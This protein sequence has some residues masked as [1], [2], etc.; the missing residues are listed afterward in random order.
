MK[1]ILRK[2]DCLEVLR[3]YPEESLE[4]VLCDP[5]YGVGFM[6]DWHDMASVRFANRGTLTN[7]VNE[8]SKVKF[9]LKAPSFRLSSKDL[10]ELTDWHT[11]WLSEAKRLLVTGGTVKIFCSNR[12]VHKQRGLCTR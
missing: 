1:L 8:D 2:G 5:P 3:E 7:M 9:K 6:K 11:K 10:S 4:T 12:T